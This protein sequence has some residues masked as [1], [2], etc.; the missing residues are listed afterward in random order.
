MTNTFFQGGKCCQCSGVRQKFG[1]NAARVVLLIQLFAPG[2]FIAAPAFLPSSFALSCSLVSLG[3]L[4]HRHR[5]VR[6]PLL[7]S[8][9]LSFP[10][11]YCTV[12]YAISVFCSHFSPTANSI[13][14]CL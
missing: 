4:F 12:R 6:R 13:R 2:M 9:S 5:F 3:A 7:S 1:N 11:L 8:L 10:L 14:L